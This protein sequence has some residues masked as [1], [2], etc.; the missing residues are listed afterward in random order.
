MFTAFV[1]AN[2]LQFGITKFCPMG[3]ILKKWAFPNR[4]KQT[5]CQSFWHR[6]LPASNNQAPGIQR[7]F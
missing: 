7:N 2:L 1:S 6:N 5:N 3:L 4:G